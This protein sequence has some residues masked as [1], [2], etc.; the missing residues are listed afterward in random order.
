LSSSACGPALPTPAAGPPR[1]RPRNRVRRRLRPRPLAIGQVRTFRDRRQRRRGRC[2]WKLGADAVTFETAGRRFGAGDVRI[3]APPSFR[4]RRGRRCAYAVDAFLRGN[5]L[6]SCANARL[7]PRWSRSSSRSCLTPT[8]PRGSPPPPA[9]AG[10]GA[11]KS[12]SRRD[13][14]HR[15][16]IMAG[17]HALPAVHLRG[18]R[19][20]RPARL[21]IEVRDILPTLEPGTSQEPASERDRE[22]VHRRQPRHISATTATPSSCASRP[23]ASTAT[24]AP[25]CADVVGPPAT[26]SCAP[27]RHA[28]DEP[29][30]EPE[31]HA[32]R[33]CGAAPRLPDGRPDAKPRV[34][35]K[36]DVD[37]SRAS[38]AASAW[39]ACLTNALRGGQDNELAHTDRGDPEVD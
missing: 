1:A 5:D 7:W 19:Q 36:Y 3:G 13:P 32:V 9:D 10:K 16:R 30:T 18:D 29:L 6:S 26:T 25:G 31:R 37:E 20:L 33:L 4:R 15:G 27:A 12:T 17:V 2:Q 39:D 34:L 23:A 14:L 22:P 38:C 35:E 24:A 11:S 28:R 8:S 21:G